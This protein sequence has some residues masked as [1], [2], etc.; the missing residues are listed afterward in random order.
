MKCLLQRV[1]EA[2]V[3]INGQ[4][5]G[6]I[7]HGLLVFICAEPADSEQQ[8]AKAVDKILNLRIFSDTAGKMN[9]SLSQVNG[10]LLVVSQFT[11]AADTSR[12]NR[13]GFS[14]AANPQLGEALYEKFLNYAKSRHPNVASG[15]F[16]ADMQ[17]H[18]I[19]DGPVTIP[20]EF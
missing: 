20:L 10:G 18:L 6:R 15:A 1:K 17:V 7:E 14:N 16:G 5:H 19:N 12:G 8:I 11:L 2:E 9:L 4:S 13:P 3:I